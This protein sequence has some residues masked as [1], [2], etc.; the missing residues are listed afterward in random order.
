MSINLQT[1]KSNF[2]RELQD[3]LWGKKT[4]LP[5]IVHKLSSRPIVKDG[6]IFQVM[7]IG[8][9]VFKKA[10]LRQTSKG[11]EILRKE[12]E[13]QLSIKDEKD[14]LLFTNQAINDGV[15]TL[16]IN[17][18]YPLKP[19][20]EHGRLDGVLLAVPKE[21]S[22]H[23]LIGKKVG[24]EIEKYIWKKRKK[25]IKVSVAN[26]TI[27][28]LL[29]GLTEYN[30]EHL[31]GGIVGTGLNFALFLAENKMV[32]LESANFNKFPQTKEGQIVDKESAHPGRS[33]FEKETA[34]AYLY[35]HF[36]IVI[37]EKRIDYPQIASTEEL[38]TISHKDIPQVSKIAKDLIKRSA[39]LVACQ[40][41]GISEF[42]KH[43]MVF[44]MEGSL[45]WKGNK[46]K[47]TVKQTVK[48]LAPKFNVKFVEIKD[49]SI[50]GAAKLVA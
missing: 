36:N 25:K 14:F 44:N 1:I 17:F 33:L 28:L 43:S 18:A 39:Q 46:Y 10:L 48:Q 47:E 15:S 5:F 34:G 2:V 13:K 22:F 16:A 21:G 24:E 32:N 50:L 40:I 38:D 3:A 20:F 26:D 23:G 12:S 6:E 27:C 7:V 8:G 29:S 31:A 30:S 9:S 11:I 45:F 41:A 19:I 42:K 4:S 49:S 35:K 37:Q